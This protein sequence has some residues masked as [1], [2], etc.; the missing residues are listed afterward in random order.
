MAVIVMLNAEPDVEISGYHR[1]CQT[2]EAIAEPG[3]FLGEIAVHCDTGRII[4][5]PKWFLR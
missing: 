1:H 5:L 4:R 2:L 3:V